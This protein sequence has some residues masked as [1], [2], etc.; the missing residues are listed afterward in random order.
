VGS[1]P[2]FK[3]LL[4]KRETL[5]KGDTKMNNYDQ[6]VI[7]FINSD[8]FDVVAYVDKFITDYN[9]ACYESGNADKQV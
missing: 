6:H 7:D 2:P 9:R 8:R 5:T 4:L 3:Y 1:H